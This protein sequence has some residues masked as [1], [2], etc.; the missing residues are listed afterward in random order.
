MAVQMICYTL[1]E[2]TIGILEN[3][4]D[5]N[6]K[7]REANTRLCVQA[8]LAESTHTGPQFFFLPS[9]LLFLFKYFDKSLNV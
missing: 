8:G 4:L 1:W 3:N 2:K 7:V 6:M 9:L 5:M